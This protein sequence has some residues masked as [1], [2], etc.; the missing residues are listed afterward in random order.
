MDPVTRK[1]DQ[2]G[3]VL[4]PKHIRAAYEIEE[5][6][7]DVEIVPTSEG[8]LIRKLLPS[9]FI[10]KS[11]NDLIELDGRNVCRNCLAKLNDLA[12][13]NTDQ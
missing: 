13:R 4:I 10:C 9:C 6:D 7:S 3:R 8:I 11:V 2:L 5:E 1:M 12:N